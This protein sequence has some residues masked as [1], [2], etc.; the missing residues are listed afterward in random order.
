MNE[1][2]SLD[3]ANTEK[4]DLLV[5]LEAQ[6]EVTSD[7]AHQLLAKDLAVQKAL[8]GQ[9]PHNYEATVYGGLAEYAL[10]A[11]DTRGERDHALGYFLVHSLQTPPPARAKDPFYRCFH[12]LTD[13]PLFTG[14][15][16]PILIFWE[17]SMIEVP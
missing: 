11:W 10:D 9:N 3:Q 13:E 6:R 14:Q 12:K 7:D 17:F 8:L 1:F 15:N 5:K 16:Q 4:N 2:S